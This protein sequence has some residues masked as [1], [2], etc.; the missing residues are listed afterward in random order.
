MT[1]T[2]AMRPLDQGGIAYIVAAYEYDEG[3]LSGPHVIAA[4][5]P[6]G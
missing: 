4:D 5:L 2:N 6:A 1:K 3:G